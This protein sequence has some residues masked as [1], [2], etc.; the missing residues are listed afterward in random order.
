MANTSKWYRARAGFYVRVENGCRAEIKKEKVR[1][2]R[3]TVD[4]EHTTTHRTMDDAKKAAVA[5]FKEH[6]H[7]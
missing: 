7:V 3:L 5:H 1:V 2:W 6:G 4:Q